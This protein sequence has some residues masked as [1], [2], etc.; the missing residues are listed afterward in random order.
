MFLQQSYPS[1]NK[2]LPVHTSMQISRNCP[3][4][5]SNQNERVIVK[6]LL[7]LDFKKFT[8]ISR[9]KN[10]AAHMTPCKIQQES[11]FFLT[12]HIVTNQIVK[13]L[14][15]KQPLSTNVTDT[16]HWQY[17]RPAIYGT[18]V[19]FG[20]FHLAPE[21]IASNLQWNPMHVSLRASNFDHWS[22]LP[23]KCT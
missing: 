23:G 5:T 11:H 10:Y 1:K 20:T 17:K 16:G 14:D 22:G 9:I 19:Q 4:A 12:L 13:A 2:I 18:G 15:I 8:H 6:P 3:K 7:Q 21:S